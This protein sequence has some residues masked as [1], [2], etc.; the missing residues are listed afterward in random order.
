MQGSR[1]VTEKFLDSF[2]SLE[3][4]INK[5]SRGGYDINFL[6]KMSPLELL[7]RKGKIDR[8]NLMRKKELEEYKRLSEE[9]SKFEKLIGIPGFPTKEK[10]EEDK[11]RLIEL[12]VKGE[13]KLRRK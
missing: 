10:I 11:K 7:K 1:N 2:L 6:K 12:K 3:N 13:I 4:F 5:F 8:A 9:I